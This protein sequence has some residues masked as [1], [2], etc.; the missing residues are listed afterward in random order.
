MD[1]DLADIK[2][3]VYNLIV[4]T[5]MA[6]IGI[7]FLKWLFTKYPIPGVTEVVTGV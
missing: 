5:L 3:G 6:I 1:F 7:T 2:P 4:I